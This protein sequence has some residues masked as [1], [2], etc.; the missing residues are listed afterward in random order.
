MSRQKKLKQFSAVNVWNQQD[1][2]SGL[3]ESMKANK[4]QNLKIIF[5]VIHCGTINNLNGSFFPA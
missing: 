3:K 4:L 1:R 5:K 2:E